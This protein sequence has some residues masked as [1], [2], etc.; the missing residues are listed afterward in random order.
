[1]L[2]VTIAG[3]S[4]TKLVVP[5]SL[6]ISNVL[7]RRADTAVFEIRKFGTRTFAPEVGQEVIILNGATRAFAGRIVT[8]D[9]EYEKLDVVGYRISCQDYTRDLDH[10]LVVESFEN[11]TVDAILASIAATYFPAGITL[12]NVDCPVVIKY[13]A[14][15]YEYPTECLRQL[16]EATDYEW[17]IDY[18]KDIHFFSKLTAAAPFELSDTGGKYV[19]ESLKIRKDITPVRNTVYVRGGEYKGDPFTVEVL[20]DGSQRVFGTEYRFSN[21]HVSVTGQAKSVGIDAIDNETDFDCLYNFQ[22]KLV[23]FRTDKKPTAASSVKISGLPWLPVIVKVRDSNSIDVFS[24]AEGNG[25]Y[26]FKIIDRSI[27]SKAGA[28]QRALAEIMAYSATLSEGEF[29]TYEDGLVAGQR[30]RV[31]STLRGVDDYYIVNKV[32]TSVMVANEGETTLLYRVSLMTT[33]TFDHIDLLQKLLNSKD[34]EIVI[35]E[36]EVLDEIES[37]DEEVVVGEAVTFTTEQRTYQW[38]PGGNPQLYWN[39]GDWGS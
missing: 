35:A 26:E 30:I 37:D 12:A 7:T 14:F 34:K 4:R 39:L 8:I 36:D 15:N 2:T 17:Y 29:N 28:R 1:M 6:R 32:E 9:E 22:E 33:R 31:Q 25:I 16:A 21:I 11:Q 20:A 10:Q 5:G 23:R 24:A 19:Y 27:K 18:D 13:I 3:T 38:G